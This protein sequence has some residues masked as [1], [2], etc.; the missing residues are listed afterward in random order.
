MT[1]KLYLFEWKKLLRQRSFLLFTLLLLLGNLFV[2]YQYEKQGDTYKYYYQLKENWQRFSEGDTSVADA[3]YYQAMT[4]EQENYIA[5][6]GD[7]LKQIPEQ[8]ESLKKTA[9]Y[10]RH[11]TYLYRDLIK[12]VSDYSELSPAG[13]KAESDVGVREYASYN[14]G[15]YFQI[16]FSFVLS[17]FVISSERK[18][19]LFLLTKGTKRGHVPLAASKLF[20]MASADLLYGIL[21][22]A[23]TYLL[24][25]YFYG[26]GDMTRKIQTVPMFRNCSLSLNIAQAMIILLAV[27]LLIGLFCALLMF[28]LSISFRREGVAMLAYAAVVALEMFLCGKIEISSSFNI[29]KC[30]N[31]FF[32]WDMSQLFGVYLNLNIFGYPV[33]KSLAVLTAGMLLACVLACAGLYRF[34]ASCQISSG[35]L[36][37]KL[38]EKITAKMSFQ[39]HHVSV[40]YFELH[41]V[42]LQQKRGYVLLLLLVWCVFCVRDTFQPVYYSNPDEGEYHRILSEISGRVTDESLEYIEEQRREL[43]A[44]YEQLAALDADAV[45]AKEML[46]HEAEMREGGVSMVEEQRDSLLQKKGDIHDKF[47]IDEK[48][49]MS[50]FY[51]Y[52]YDL[53]AFFA[54]AA[55]LVLWVSEIEASDERKGLYPLLAATKTG[56]RKIQRKK[57]QT[58]LTGMLW[59]VLCV[60]L[61]QFLRY[62]RID[63]FENAEQA[64]SDFTMTAFSSGLSVG[65]FIVLLMLAKAAVFVILCVLLL[66]LVRRV[67]NTAII[68]G[69]GVGCVGLTVLL[70]WYF[71]RDLTVIGLGLFM[72]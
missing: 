53:I 62:L 51:D 39:W 4:E 59:C 61:P 65:A 63:H 40:Y 57:A 19:G 56:K 11:D 28:S 27:R 9:N 32:P 64:L 52:K 70:M 17:Y 8:A 47:W 68:L 15:I 35:S 49:Y 54:G 69:A 31:I 37:E 7:Y 20:T 67:H 33:S 25:G 2:I 55:A 22:E 43:E 38:R 48:N 36:L 14:Y 45:D 66:A 30:V 16:I 72:G 6:Y 24:F 50:T 58:A 41:K 1:G 10:Q 18:K 46:R 42:F 23:G 29:A 34:S 5:S 12:T 60:L 3:E 21:Q 71:G 13:M 44:L 26:Y